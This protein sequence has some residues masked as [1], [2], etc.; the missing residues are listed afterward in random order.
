M[1]KIVPARRVNMLE[2]RVQ[3]VLRGICKRATGHAYRRAEFFF[4]DCWFTACCTDSG[5]HLE[6]VKRCERNLPVDGFNEGCLWVMAC[7]AG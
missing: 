2:M 7:T 5:A 6:L 1:R 4:E 3:N